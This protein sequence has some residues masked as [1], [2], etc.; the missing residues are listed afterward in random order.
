MLHLITSKFQRPNRD[1]PA[2]K[3]DKKYHLDWARFI[4]SH[5]NNVHQKT[6]TTRL[7]VNKSFY[8]G[9]Q[10]IFKEDQEP[11]L[12]DESGDVRNRIKFVKN[13][14]RPMAEQIRGSAIRMDYSAKAVN[15]SARS[16]DRRDMALE[17]KLFKM[18]LAN[19]VSPGFRQTLQDNENLGDT[20][21][22]TKELF[23]KTFMDQHAAALNQLIA[24]VESRNKMEQI[25]LAITENILFGGVGVAKCYEQNGH[26]QI[27]DQDTLYWF[28]DV[29]ARQRDLSDSEY[30]GEYWYLVPT[31]V[32][33][34]WPDISPIE[35]DSINK[36]VQR[37]NQNNAAAGIGAAPQSD[38]RVPVFEVY[39]RDSEIQEYGWIMDEFGLE[40]FVRINDDG[41]D[42]QYTDEDL[43]EPSNPRDFEEVGH[44]LKVRKYVDVLRYCIFIPHEILG[45]AHSKNIDRLDIVLE[46]GIL[47]YQEEDLLHPGNIHFPYKCYC[48]AL[49]EGE[50]LSPIDD[51]ID[52]QRF[53]NRIMSIGESHVNNARGSGI[54][55]DEEALDPQRGEAGMLSDMNLGKPVRVRAKRKGVQ[56]VVGEYKGG[57][58]NSTLQLFGIA[59]NVQVGIQDT[60]GMN[61]Q[62]TGSQGGAELVGVT[63][64]MIQQGT[65]M[66]EPFYFALSQVMLQIYQSIASLGKRIYAKSQ[67]DLVVMVG[68][69]YSNI[70]QITEDI[71]NED[72]RVFIQRSTPE[73]LERETVDQM[74]MQLLEFG[75][76][77]KARFG[78]IIGRASMEDLNA[79][80]RS[81]MKEMAIEEQQAAR[82]QER[83]APQLEELARQEQERAMAREDAAHLREDV[84]KQMD[85]QSKEDIAMLHVAGKGINE[86]NRNDAA[87]A[88][89]SGASRAGG[90]GE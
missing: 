1:Q 51:A 24:S 72:F 15:I 44:T 81:R 30:M 87:A 40:R 13:L 57:V 18:R 46:C 27:I 8:K 7:L 20:A 19:Q 65:L 61:D 45:G 90:E 67:H 23:E 38:G 53:I 55:Y 32:M 47:P 31:E 43:I 77:D 16:K 34:R 86:A 71:A 21:D 76:L 42:S 36:Y 39:W 41:E 49:H 14:I 11:F 50:I 64:L 89:S 29:A 9:N 80:I 37:L 6:R 25:K 4:V 79:A 3:K 69:E 10:W 82:D 48:W 73:H 68:D 54:I 22:Q 62:M 75:I 74:A 59:Q 58:S 33:E 70:I 35:R 88:K 56:N 63:K 52:P 78:E 28:Y 12:M 2:E 66:Q 83:A 84:N 5:A 60:T 85:R 26:H 17:I